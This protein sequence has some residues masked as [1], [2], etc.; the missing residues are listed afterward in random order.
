MISDKQA[1]KKALSIELKDFF[2][3]DRTIPNNILVEM[4]S[5]EFNKQPTVLFNFYFYKNQIYP[6]LT[7]CVFVFLGS[8]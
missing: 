1:N 4:A 7:L 2:I 8:G 3:S 6:N 5:V